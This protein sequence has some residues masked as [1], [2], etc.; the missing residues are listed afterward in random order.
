V[1]PEV[2]Q[3]HGEVNSMS[4]I[5]SF[6]LTLYELYTGQLPFKGNHNYFI[7]KKIIE[8]EVVI[9]D[10]CSEVFVVA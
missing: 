10:S 4:D 1:A 5:W 2:V 9:P 6:A 8:D 7:F 3:A